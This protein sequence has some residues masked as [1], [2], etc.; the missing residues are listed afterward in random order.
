V[1]FLQ[2]LIGNSAPGKLNR[3]SRSKEEKNMK[4]RTW[5]WMTVAYLFAALAMPAQARI[6]YTPVNVTLP[7]NGYYPIDLNHDGITDFHFQRYSGRC[8]LGPGNLYF[9]RVAPNLTGGGIVGTL[10]EA[11]ALQSGVQIDSSQ[12]F[13]GGNS[14]MYQKVTG[15]GGGTYGQW[16][17]TYRL[18]LGLKFLIAGQV[19]YGWAQL[20]THAGGTDTLYG[21]AY[22]TIPGMAIKTGQILDSPDEPG[23]GPDS[24]ESQDSGPTALVAP[25]L[26]ATPQLQSSGDSA[27]MPVGMVSQ[28]SPSQ[29]HKSKHHQ[30]KL[31]DVGTFGGP[32]SFVES[33]FSADINSRGTAIVFAD[34]SLPDPYSPNC[35]QPDCL[36]NHSGQ[37]QDGVLTD[38]GV[39]PGVNSSFPT[40]INDRGAI[41]GLSENGN[42]DPLTGFP[43][44]DAVVW[45][46]DGIVDLG[47][48]G[49]NASLANAINNR[50]QVTGGAL[51]AIPDSFGSGL[52][53]APWFP[54]ATQFRAFLWKHGVMQ[55]L[56]TLGGNDAEGV[57][58]NDRG[59]VAGISYTNTTPNGTTGLPTQDPFFW[60]NGN[61][62]DIG[63]LGGTSGT[64]YWM[65]SRGQVAGE[66]NLA[67]DVHFHA[68]LW[69]RGALTDLGTLGGDNSSARWINDAGEVVGRAAL[70]PGLINRHGF[71]WKN[72]VMTDL[73]ILAGDTCATAYSINSSEQIVGVSSPC[74]HSGHGFLWENGGPIVDLQSLVLPGSN[75]TIKGVLFVNDAG[76]IAGFGA[77]SNGDLHALLLIPCDEKHPGECEDNSMIEAPAS[78]T[79]AP[80]AESVLTTKQNGSPQDTVNPL[81]NRFGR[82]YHLPGQPT[83]PRD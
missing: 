33:P 54:V 35:F 4:F 6:V 1:N 48:L 31:I 21:F 66:S 81:R 60:E 16:L 53:V 57:L 50:G 11:A 73:G 58:L 30:Y 9:L 47:T 25:P 63:T 62:V 34:T 59:Q 37:W 36:V 69:T 61:M 24:A 20:S 40:G 83:A 71:L 80:T 64:P 39:L 18:Y 51:N 74:G 38:L 17:Y 44:V 46:E 19:H 56:G 72:G 23:I 77:N 78:Q 5:M 15:C 8:P 79:S 65:N 41:A 3:H 76:E 22:E 82:G 13:Y 45:T 14:L 75:L 68:F 26:S 32:S 43:E 42:I 55:D 49:G 52:T 27:A 28:D 29:D 2:V 10:Y 67:G 12:S 7:T 70:Y